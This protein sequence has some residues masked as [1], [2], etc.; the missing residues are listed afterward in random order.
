[1]ELPFSP[2]NVSHYKFHQSS[3]DGLLNLDLGFDYLL[4][5]GSFSLRYD[6]FNAIFEGQ[7]MSTVFVPQCFTHVALMTQIGGEKKYSD[8]MCSTRG[9]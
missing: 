2:F 6:V 4:L 1:M 8:F 7:F 5:A 9:N 3:R